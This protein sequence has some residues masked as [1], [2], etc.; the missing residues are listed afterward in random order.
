MTTALII[1][2]GAAAAGA[3]LALSHR[4]NIKITVIDIGLK[5]EADREQLVETLA[6]SSPDEWD[7]HTIELS[8]SSL[9]PHGIPASLRSAYSAQTIHSEMRASSPALL[10]LT[11]RTLL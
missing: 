11:V 8:R 3:A 1:G 6:S 5:L 2:S 4:E 9:L 10:Q 7:E